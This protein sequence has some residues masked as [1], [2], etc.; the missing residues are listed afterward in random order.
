MDSEPPSYGPFREGAPITW[1]FCLE[2]GPFDIENYFLNVETY[3][4]VLRAAGF[5]DVRGI[6]R[7]CHRRAILAIRLQLANPTLPRMPEGVN[8]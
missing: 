2:D 3:E 8:S 4:E 1:T 7:C 6:S 5:R